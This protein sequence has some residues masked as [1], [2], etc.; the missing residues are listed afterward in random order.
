MGVRIVFFTPMVSS[1]VTEICI[2]MYNHT[3]LLSLFL[4]YLPVI[5]SNF[6]I[7]VFRTGNH[8]FN[9][10]L[11][12]STRTDLRSQS[13]SV[14]LSHFSSVLFP[15]LIFLESISPYRVHYSLF[16]IWP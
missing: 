9:M 11:T 3:L 7:R 14:L 6:G 8:F 2:I 12:K 16:S 5:V 10:N 15:G 4:S 13:P 1:Y